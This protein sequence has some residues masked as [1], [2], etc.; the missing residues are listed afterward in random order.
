[1]APEIWKHQ[2]YDP[3]KADVW[4]LG[5]TFYIMATGGLPWD[6]K[7]P[8]YYR[9]ME[10]GLEEANFGIPSDFL[11]VLRKMLIA[12]PA[13]RAT[14]KE[15]KEML[16]G[17]EYIKAS[18]SVRRMDR[19]ANEGKGIMRAQTMSGMTVLGLLPKQ[20]SGFLIKRQ[21]SDA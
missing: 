11:R 14:L 16:F 6:F 13:E 2:N 9:A 17:K 5:V 1:M 12:D 19:V 21:K 15:V 7:S 8:S 18:V 3:F 20:R 4:S 10:Y